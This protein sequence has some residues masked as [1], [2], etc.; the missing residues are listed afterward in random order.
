MVDS[1]VHLRAVADEGDKNHKLLD[2]VQIGCVIT[3][4]YSAFFVA[5]SKFEYHTLVSM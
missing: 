3:Q 2:F 1:L 5:K 4:K